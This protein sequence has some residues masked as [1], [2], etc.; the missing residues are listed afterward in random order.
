MFTIKLV[1][2]EFSPRNKKYYS[3]DFI[4][5]FEC[6]VARQI[7]A[8]QKEIDTKIALQEMTKKID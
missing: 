1:K 5:G 8:D 3:E 2:L 4:K 7:Q 6:G